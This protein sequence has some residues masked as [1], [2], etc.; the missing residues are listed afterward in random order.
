MSR[1]SN[2]PTLLI[3]S[4]SVLHELNSFVLFA[5]RLMTIGCYPRNVLLFVLSS[6]LRLKS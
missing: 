1:N 3:P 2:P 6:T 5:S 4:N